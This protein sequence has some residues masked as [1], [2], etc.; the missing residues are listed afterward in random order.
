MRC[1]TRFPL[2]SH[3]LFL[4]S[5]A[6]GLGGCPGSSPAPPDGDEDAIDDADGG[7]DDGSDEG[8]DAT[9]DGDAGTGEEEAPRTCRGPGEE[10]ARVPACTYEVF[11]SGGR[12][13]AA[14]VC[15]PEPLPPGPLPV[16]LGFH[17]G[18]GNATRWQ[19]SIPL[20]LSGARFGFVTAFMQ[21]CRDNLQDCSPAQGSYLWNVGK[22]AEPGEIDD[23]AYTLDLLAHLETAL[24]LEIDPG[25]RFATGH[26]L[27]GIFSYSLLC[28]QPGLLTAIGPISA[29]PTDAT[30]SPHAGTSIFHLHGQLDE[31][32][33]FHTGCCSAAQQAVGDAEYLPECAALPRCFN[34]SNWWPP[35]RT[36]V[37]PFTT[38]TGLD[39]L[40]T[41]G[42]GCAGEPEV[43]SQTPEV[44]CRAYP[45]CVTDR[46]AEFCLVEGVDHNL[47]A[48]DA[49]HDVRAHLL[50]RF[51][52]HPA[53]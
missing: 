5:L 24:G 2:P 49:A 6:L 47:A 9:G 40:A 1:R 14:I 15:R 28:D 18:G 29:P 34:P 38:V 43:I 4:L 21:G 26:S 41:S 32:V 22:A 30:C 39:A 42:L 20:H 36:G 10:P 3:S 23:Q 11:A 25:C 45:G 13:R 35:V 53:R 33:P 12:T 52:A 51:A 27:G 7:L 37:H 44:T 17:G 8:Q 50:P 19:E 48:L 31:N 46:T 16:V